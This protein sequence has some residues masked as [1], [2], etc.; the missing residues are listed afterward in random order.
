MGGQNKKVVVAALAAEDEQIILDFCAA[1]VSS[2]NNRPPPTLMRS[3]TRQ[4]NMEMKENPMTMLAT[5]ENLRLVDALCR[6]DFVS[7]IRKTFHTLAPGAL[8]Q[9]N[10]HVYALAYYLE[11]VL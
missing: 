3:L 8:L 4:R 5:P 9:M 6:T 11:L 10:F 2:P 1:M 7:F